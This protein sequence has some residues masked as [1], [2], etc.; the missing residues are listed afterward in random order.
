MLQQLAFQVA[1]W[2]NA[3]SDLVNEP[4]SDTGCEAI[5]ATSGVSPWDSVMSLILMLLLGVIVVVTEPE[6]TIGAQMVVLLLWN[7]AKYGIQW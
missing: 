5:L 6:V 4:R 7:V 1:V 2:I 3:K